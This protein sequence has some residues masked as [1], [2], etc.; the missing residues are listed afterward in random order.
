M[1]R[2]YV[3]SLNLGNRA[4]LVLAVTTSRP[5]ALRLAA[6]AHEVGQPLLTMTMVDLADSGDPLVYDS[7]T[8]KAELVAFSRATTAPARLCTDRQP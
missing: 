6:V 5:R 4:N 1:V 3:H 7:R 8:S 2:Y